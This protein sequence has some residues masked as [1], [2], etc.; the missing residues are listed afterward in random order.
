ME[1]KVVARIIRRV[2]TNPDLGR[3]VGGCVG[4][5]EISRLRSGALLD[6]AA[7]M[8]K[9]ERSKHAARVMPDSHSLATVKMGSAVT[10]KLTELATKHIAWA[11]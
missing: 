2:P 11:S 7:E 1:R 6:A 8:T 9:N 4:D 3:M 5:E 10:G